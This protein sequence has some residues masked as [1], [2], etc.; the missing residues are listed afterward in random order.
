MAFWQSNP[1]S[2]QAFPQMHSYNL[3][4]GTGRNQAYSARMNY[5]SFPAQGYGYRNAALSAQINTNVGPSPSGPLGRGATFTGNRPFTARQSHTGFYATGSRMGS[6]EQNQET[7][8]SYH[9]P[10]SSGRMGQFHMKTRNLS[11]PQ[12]GQDRYAARMIPS[13][14]RGT[15][16][17]TG[18]WVTPPGSNPYPQGHPVVTQQ[19]PAFGTAFRQRA[20]ANRVWGGKKKTRKSKKSQRKTRRNH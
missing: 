12:A 1:P 17:F 7:T 8:F 10:G 9:T 3:R 19:A 13:Y 5:S 2:G 4:S 16:S 18:T 14:N 6:Q 20:Q 11:G 15:G